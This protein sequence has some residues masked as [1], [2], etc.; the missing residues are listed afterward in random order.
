VGGSSQP[1]GPIDLSVLAEQLK[2]DV[3]NVT[4]TSRE[5]PEERTARLNAERAEAEHRRR[6]F[7]VAFSIVVLAGATTFAM[8]VTAQPSDANTQAWARTVASAIIGGIVG[9]FTGSAA[10]APK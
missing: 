6:V 2:Y 3:Y 1:T 5:H 7:W 9:Y 4:V 8:I 10:K